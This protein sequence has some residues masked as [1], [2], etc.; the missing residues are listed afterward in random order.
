MGYLLTVAEA[1]LFEFPKLLWSCSGEV[2]PPPVLFTPW[3][4]AL[5]IFAGF[6]VVE[7]GVCDV[8]CINATSCKIEN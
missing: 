5:T 4:L 2:L 7:V 8:S 6:V 1:I 3:M